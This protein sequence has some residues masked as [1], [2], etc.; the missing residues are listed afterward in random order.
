MRQ[1]KTT[2]KELT[3][4]YRA[5][6]RYGILCNAVALGLAVATPAKADSVNTTGNAW[7]F[8]DVAF[9]D[10][11][12]ADGQAA[13]GGRREATST[14][15]GKYHNVFPQYNMIGQSFTLNNSD[16]YFGPLTLTLDELDSG[17]KFA[18]NWQAPDGNNGVVDMDIAG[19]AG[20][21]WGDDYG[22]VGT[23]LRTKMTEIFSD[24]GYVD[25]GENKRLTNAVNEAVAGAQG[26]VYMM[27]QK[28][29]GSNAGN[30]TLNNVDA[31]IDGATVNV[32]NI[33]V[34]NGSNLNFVRRD[35][36]LL[37]TSAIFYTNEEDI[38]SNGKTTLNASDTINITGSHVS[39]DSG[40][41]LAIN[42]TNGATFSNNIATAVITEGRTEGTVKVGGVNTTVWREN[43]TGGMGGAIYNE[44]TMNNISGTFTGNQAHS[45]L[46][47]AY[48]AEEGGEIVSQGNVSFG[49]LGGAVYNTG[50]MSFN[51]ATFGGNTAELGNS[52]VRGGAINN[53]GGTTTVSNSTFTN[54]TASY[55]GGAINANAGDVIVDHS[56]FTSNNG[57]IYGGAISSVFDPENKIQ[58][59]NNSSFTNNSA[60]L[61]GAIAAYYNLE[62]DDSTFT[63]NTTTIVEDGGGAIV[64]GGHGKATITGSTFSGNKSN[65]GGAI[66][67]RP[68]IAGALALGDNDV[69]ANKDGHWLVIEGS[70]FEN[71]IADATLV[72]G[73]NGTAHTYSTAQMMNG[74]G[75]A[76][77]NGF[78]G[79]T[80]NGVVH[81]NEIIGSTFTSN[82]AKNNGGAIYNEG[83]LAVTDTGFNTNTAAGKGGAVYNKG[84][85]TVAAKAGDVSFSGNTAAGNANDIYNAGTLNLN[86]AS[87]RTISLTGG[88]DGAD[89]T[90]NIN[91]AGTV[92]TS[93]IKNQ[94][95]ALSN[96]ELHLTDADLTGSTVTVADGATINTIDN[97][98]NDY[99]TGAAI[100]LADGANI[101]GDIDFTAG[102]ADKY[103]AVLG[104]TVNYNVGN[105]IG[106]VV[107]TGTKNVQVVSDGATVG[108]SQA[109]F[110][111]TSGATF[112]SSGAADGMMKVSGF[113]GGIET[114]ADATATI[115]ELQYQLTANESVNTDKTFANNVS[116]TG[117]GTEDTDEGLTLNADLGTT[118]GANVEIN[119]L[120]LAGTGTYR[121][122][123]MATTRINNSKID[124]NI[125]NDG[126]LISDPTTYS[127]V[128]DNSDFASFDNDTFTGTAQLL[129]TGNVNLLNGVVFE[130]G[131]TITGAGRTNLASGVTNFNNTA[132]SNTVTVSNGATFDGTLVSTGTVD[133]RNGGIDAGLGTLT[134]NSGSVFVDADYVSGQI[135]TFANSQA[136]NKINL[137]NSE[138]GTA[139]SVTLDLG[140]NTLADGATFSGGYYTQMTDNNDGTVTF[141]DKLINETAMANYVGT[142]N[143]AAP[144]DASNATGLFKGV[145]DNAA[146]IATI[147]ASDVMNSGINSTLVGQIT[148]NQDAIATINTS[149]AMT[150]GINS[151]LVG[152]IT[153]N[154]D[155]ITVLNGGAST[156]GSVANSIATALAN[157]GDAYQTASQVASNLDDLI[158]VSSGVVT[159][160]N[161]DGTTEATTYTADKVD[162]LLTG[163]TV[164]AN[165]ASVTTSG[166]ASV[167]SLT[168]GSNTVDA[169]DGTTGTGS[170]T[171]AT[172]ATVNN[173]ISGVQTSVNGIVDGTTSIAYD[174]STSGLTATTIAG[175]INEVE[176]R[177]DT[178]ETNIT[179]LQGN[180]AMDAHAQSSANYDA[181]DKVDAALAAV[182]GA[183]YTAETNITT[184]QGNV[185]MDADAQ[186]SAG[187]HQNDKVDAALAAV[188]VALHTAE[189][190]ITTLQGNVAMDA[191]ATSSAGYAAGDKVDT[192]LAAVDVALHTA[193]TNIGTLSSLTTDNK[194]DLVVAINEVDSH[195]D[196][197]TTNIAKVLNG[198]AL[199]NTVYNASGLSSSMIFNETDGGGVMYK[200][201]GG[202]TAT[203]GATSFVGVDGDD[204]YAM[205]NMY[206]KSATSST[207]LIVS[208]DGAYITTSTGGDNPSIT[209]SAA[210]KIATMGA[211]NEWTGN[212]TFTGNVTL[213]D[214]A[215]DTVTVNGTATFAQQINAT[216]GIKAG[217]NT[218][219]VDGT[220]TVGDGTDS[221]TL[222]QNTLTTTTV[223]ATTVNAGVNTSLVDGTLTVGDGTDSSTLTQDTLTTT[224]VNATNV[225]AQTLTLSDGA[226]T[227]TT[228]TLSVGT[229]GAVST[230][231][232]SINA[233]TGSVTAATVN[234]NNLQLGAAPVMTGVTTNSTDMS[235]LVLGTTAASDTSLTTTA[236]TIQAD[237]FVLNTSMAYADAKL[238]Q[239]NAYTDERVDKLD[240]NLSSGIASAIA[241]TSVSTGGVQ[242]GEVAVSGGYGYYNGQSAAA[243]GAAMGLSN[244]WSV[245]AG[246]GVSNSDV[247]F[248]AGTTYKFK[249]F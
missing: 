138:Y 181:G 36:D 15:A 131:A 187:Y 45:V 224:T 175:A 136:I 185:A 84:T 179:T 222:T 228:A 101:K 10:Q 170:N 27:L 240:K 194:T 42:A 11:H 229:D 60:Q 74:D 104:S 244:R 154:Q 163:G 111:S 43:A 137:I 72:G 99:M 219:L 218:T 94:T 78:V 221:S 212:N 239:A 211:D 57:G 133:T 214:A 44:G 16:A 166:N 113:G 193:E 70:T 56:T 207:R 120:K 157:G 73:T 96:G 195:V 142:A 227:P 150:S 24:A 220:L 202:A 192:A 86:A 186:S 165:F 174:N 9:S 238:V 20:I 116:L 172:V 153:T 216:N 109:Q 249:A 178:A 66:S 8:G 23:K 13:F 135:D 209:G 54:N 90:L 168:I 47:H 117:A 32:K 177:V 152:Q 59:K 3:A 158:T 7:V 130:S 237:Q 226:T 95:V 141:S 55:M 225:N 75:G 19:A 114:A 6:L 83:V 98:I 160:H 182:D 145:E 49:G 51:G 30:M 67:T 50:T 169:I 48:N 199:Q 71:N 17:D 31:V 197:N 62:V 88:V 188:D 232:A 79:S 140:G 103:A 12:V 241:L 164:N 159:F 151:T 37:N 242:K 201:N 200:S 205:A 110:T 29:D 132:S 1:S 53:N 18:F 121:N 148:T 76:I 143:T 210:T 40:A 247:S 176:G 106:G 124:V 235:A 171:L 191:D 89:G 108:I 230:G 208:T 92:E 25:E 144:G 41:E 243:F 183:L 236:A 149:D 122:V 102:T 26:A 100:T 127:A 147:N 39:V 134:N 52:A 35:T 231:N 146:A 69:T 38:V 91:G 234:T 119:D 233:G 34:T 5:V 85:M 246:A 156:A 125:D 64:L 206:A 28:G 77:W 155:A 162:S 167:G 65:L 68:N 112:E 58:I 105:F 173:A 2:L 203:G 196:T 161:T 128:V 46:R 97:L 61:G 198:D 93:T 81:N 184:L 189:T 139:N 14:V 4:A 82:E 129:N 118:T 87:G 213:G 107:G 204:T 223:N 63:N 33:S 217:T 248:R 180:V 190:N 21:V 245:N 126:I 215:S 123:A 80:V 22:T 115:E